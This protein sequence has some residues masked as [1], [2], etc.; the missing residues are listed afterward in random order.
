MPKRK[1]KKES[2]GVRSVKVKSIRNK[3]DL[4]NPRTYDTNS[5]GKS[6]FGIP[7]SDFQEFG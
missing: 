7:L 3:D 6:K 2:E 1:R 4:T 5:K